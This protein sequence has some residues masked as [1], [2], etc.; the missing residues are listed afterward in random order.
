MNARFMEENA[1]FKPI[2]RKCSGSYFLPKPDRPHQK[3]SCQ[4]PARCLDVNETGTQKLG[5]VFHHFQPAGRI[6]CEGSAGPHC[7]PAPSESLWP[8]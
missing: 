7:T 5:M 6:S 3:P 8:W 1:S 2:R 4:F